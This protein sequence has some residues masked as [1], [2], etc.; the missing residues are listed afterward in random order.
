MS[1]LSAFGCVVAVTFLALPAIAA[2]PDPIENRLAVQKAMATAR[3]FL[4]VNMPQDA[5]GVLEVEVAKAD[6][7]KA[8]LSLLREAYLA[9]LYRLEKAPSP[10]AAK[11]AQVRR[12]LALLGGS[13]PV[14][15]EPATPPPPA[16]SSDARRRVQSARGCRGRLQ[17]RG[18]HDGSAA[19]CRDYQSE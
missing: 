18:L 10:D 15:K 19:L 14:A 11:V 9:E 7:S 6:G 1:R 13:A 17:E 4:E 2:D 3:Q 16:D 8:Y 5:V 12:K